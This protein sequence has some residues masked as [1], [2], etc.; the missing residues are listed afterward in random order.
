MFARIAVAYNESPEAG[1]ALA[2]AIRLAKTLGSEL[3]VITI[4]ED[5]PVF[6]SYATAADSSLARTLAKTGRSIMSRCM[7]KPASLLHGAA[8]S[9]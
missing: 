5:S 3:R 2:T 8:S 7:P 9:T 6:A 4:K 1:H